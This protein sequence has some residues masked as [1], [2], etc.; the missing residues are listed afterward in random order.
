LLISVAQAQN[1]GAE[2]DLGVAAYKQARY[3]EA[4][5]HFKQSIALDPNRAESHMNLALAFAQQYIPG[6]DTP[7]NN[8]MAQ[9]AIG[10]FEKV[11]VLNPNPE[12]EKTRRKGIASLLFNMKQLEAAKEDHRKVLAID[13][14][15]AETYYAIGVIDWTESYQP[16]MEERAKLDLKPGEPFFNRSECWSLRAKTEHIVK[17][18]IEAL[19]KALS[20]SHD[21]DDAMAYMN[22]M[23]RERADIQ[24]GNKQAYDADMKMAD[25]WVDMTMATKEEKANRSETPK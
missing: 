4:I 13:P 14:N 21:H 22:L 10:E 23:Y 24:C 18:G 3:E 19:T 17:D 11:L 8:R 12:E 1:A 20:L 5:T 25:K 6:A 7:D 2:L 15:D 16:H 9:Q